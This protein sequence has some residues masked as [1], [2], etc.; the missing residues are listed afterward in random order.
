MHY[1]VVPGLTFAMCQSGILTPP[2]KAEFAAAVRHLD[3]VK[4]VSAIT[5]DCAYPYQLLSVCVQ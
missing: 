1:R 5:G 4:H 3:D 2:V